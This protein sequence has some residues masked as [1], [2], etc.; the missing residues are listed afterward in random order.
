MERPHWQIWNRAIIYRLCNLPL[1]GT[2]LFNSFLPHFQQHENS[3][4][5]ALAAKDHITRLTSER[6]ADFLIP[7][8]SH[9]HPWK[10]ATVLSDQNVSGEL[11]VMGKSHSH[12][13]AEKKSSQYGPCFLFWWAILDPRSWPSLEVL[14]GIVMGHLFKHLHRVM[15][16]RVHCSNGRWNPVF[17]IGQ[18]WI[19]PLHFG[20]FRSISY[21]LNILFRPG[22]QPDRV[23]DRCEKWT[24]HRSLPPLTGSLMMT[25]SSL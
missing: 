5:T 6:K 16:I 18:V 22:S 1:T 4:K 9:R 24:E 7:N 14:D 2:G 21:L 17:L 23:Y 25:D 20:A 10:N 19:P 11:D 12:L 8:S 3:M 15:S 13:A